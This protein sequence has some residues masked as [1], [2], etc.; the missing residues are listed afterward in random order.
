VARRNPESINTKLF[1]RSGFASR[2][3]PCAR[4]VML[5]LQQSVRIEDPLAEETQCGECFEHFR[6]CSGCFDD[7]N[8]V[9]AR[10]RCLCPK[11]VQRL[12]SSVVAIMPKPFVL[13]E[14]FIIAKRRLRE[15]F[16]RRFTACPYPIDLRPAASDAVAFQRSLRIETH[17]FY[18]VLWESDE[19]IG[20]I[21]VS[22][23]PGGERFGTPWRITAAAGPSWPRRGE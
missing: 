16:C 3:A 20:A 8:G 6:N 23:A 13:S 15:E 9:S 21:G 10:G 11:G 12:H 22:G 1:P 2:V 17:E 4:A 7:L 5:E 18:N 19:T 14:E